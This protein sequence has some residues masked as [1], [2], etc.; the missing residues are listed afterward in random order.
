MQQGPGSDA[1]MTDL[2]AGQ[3]MLDDAKAEVIPEK[4][5]KLAVQLDSVLAAKRSA[6]KDS[7]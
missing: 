6:A 3:Q 5:V 2:V 7:R 1:K 4:I